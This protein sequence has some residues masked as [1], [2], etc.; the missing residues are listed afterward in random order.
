MSPRP[1]RRVRLRRALRLVDPSPLL[2]LGGCTTGVAAA[3]TTFGL[4]AGL[5]AGTAAMFLLALLTESDDEATD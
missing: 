1:R 3:W 5:A 2:V 4:G